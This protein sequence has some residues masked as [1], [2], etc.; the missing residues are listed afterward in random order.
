MVNDF[1]AALNSFQKTQR[2]AA[3]KEREF[4]ARVRAS[5]RVSVSNPPYLQDRTVRVQ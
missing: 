1:S 2:K 5:S 4:V 3:D